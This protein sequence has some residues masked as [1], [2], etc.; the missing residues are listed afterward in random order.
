MIS[1]IDNNMICI[2]QCILLS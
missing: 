2:Q 1:S